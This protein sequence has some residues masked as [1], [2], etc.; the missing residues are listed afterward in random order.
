MSDLDTSMLSAE[1]LTEIERKVAAF[2]AVITKAAIRRAEKRRNA[3]P[4]IV[5]RR[6]LRKLLDV[7]AIQIALL[8]RMLAGAP[9]T[10]LAAEYMH[11]SSFLSGHL[12]GVMHDQ[13][14]Y[15]NGDFD[16]E[17]HR[18]LRASRDERHKVW[19]PLLLRRL[20]AKSPPTATARTAAPPP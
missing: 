1:E 3:N 4:D 15:I 18:Y 9:Y 8:E 7:P 12:D 10:E 16:C 14:E 2:R 11:S 13:C 19:H 17:W 6:R 20:R 5:E